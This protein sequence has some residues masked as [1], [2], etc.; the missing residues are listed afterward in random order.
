MKKILK[1]N[2]FLKEA[3]LSGDKRMSY[4]L[5]RTGKSKAMKNLVSEIE[6]S[7]INNFDIKLDIINDIS[8]FPSDDDKVIWIRNYYI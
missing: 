1:Y 5:S 7:N 6:T 3:T 4:S 2:S 8:D